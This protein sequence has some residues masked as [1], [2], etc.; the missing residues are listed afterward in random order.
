M[1]SCDG[2]FLAQTKFVVSHRLWKVGGGVVQTKKILVAKQR[3]T[4]IN[5]HYRQH[6]MKFKLFAHH[7]YFS[8]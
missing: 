7:I 8:P 2:N 4:I 6:T 3:P 1:P 5:Y